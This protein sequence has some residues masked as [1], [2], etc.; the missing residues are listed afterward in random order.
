MFEGH[1]RTQWR[2]TAEI[3]ACIVNMHRDPK[4]SKHMQWTDCYPYKDIP[5][6]QELAKAPFGMLKEVFFDNT[7]M[8]SNVGRPRRN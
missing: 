8:T 1:Q 6:Q 4:K 2:H 3:L 7:R 5:Y